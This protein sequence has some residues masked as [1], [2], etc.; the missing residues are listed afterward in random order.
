MPALTLQSASSNS[1]SNTCQHN[2]HSQWWEQTPNLD[3][4]GLFSRVSACKHLLEIPMTLSLEH[5]CLRSLS[6]L[7]RPQGFVPH[8]SKIAPFL[9]TTYNSFYHI[10]TN[11]K[12]LEKL[13]DIWL[14]LAEH[15]LAPTTQ[16][17][18]NLCKMILP[19]Y[20]HSFF[21]W[22]PEVTAGQKAGHWVTGQ[23][24]NPSGLSQLHHDSINPREPSLTLPRTD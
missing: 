21:P 18:H 17:L 2:T 5:E 1:S 11:S 16:F 20:L 6:L 22:D 24:M 10:I 3:I 15:M 12:L 23:V 14:F 8:M 13:F 7:N 4:M 19:F 9:T